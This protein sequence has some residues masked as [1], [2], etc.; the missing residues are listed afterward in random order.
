ML[1]PNA[2]GVEKNLKTLKPFLG[3]RPKISVKIAN[4]SK[5][6]KR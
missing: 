6:I 2:P 1:Q 4:F 5:R 3:S